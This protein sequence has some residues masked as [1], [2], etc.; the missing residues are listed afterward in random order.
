LVGLPLS[1]MMVTGM[2]QGTGWNMDYIFPAES[3]LGGAIIAVVV[4]QVAA[5]YPVWRVARIGV[6]ESIRSKE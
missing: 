1:W 2:S 5:L 6:L 3:F 4:S